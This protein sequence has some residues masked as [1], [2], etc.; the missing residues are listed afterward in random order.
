MLHRPPRSRRCRRAASLQ[1][2]GFEEGIASGASDDGDT[3]SLAARHEPTGAT[4][5]PMASHPVSSL[6]DA[7]FSL[8]R[9]PS[10]NATLTQVSRDAPLAHWHNLTPRHMR[11]RRFAAAM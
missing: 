4:I 11:P 6:K 7:A 5:T 9:R 8:G 1:G 2:G 10:P 3:L